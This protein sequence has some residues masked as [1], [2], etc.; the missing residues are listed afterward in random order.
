MTSEQIRLHVEKYLASGRKIQKLP[1]D[2]NRFFFPILE[3]EENLF[4][5]FAYKLY[6]DEEKLFDV[7]D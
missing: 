3:N 6:E 1:D 7:L 5:K 4:D 2:N